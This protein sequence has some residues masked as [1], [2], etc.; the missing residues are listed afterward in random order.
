MM[1]SRTKQQ[2]KELGSIKGINQ[3][4]LYPVITFGGPSRAGGY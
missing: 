2:P 4:I 1:K 3:D